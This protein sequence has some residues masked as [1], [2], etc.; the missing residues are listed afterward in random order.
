MVTGP[1][2]A[3]TV[4]LVQILEPACCVESNRSYVSTIGNAACL[5]DSRNR[6]RAYRYVLSHSDTITGMATEE[7]GTARVGVLIRMQ[8]PMHDALARRAAS[9]HVSVN[10]YLERLVGRD[11]GEDTDDFVVVPSPRF[12]AKGKNGT[13]RPTKGARKG[14]TLRVVPNLRQRINERAK[15]LHLTANDYLESLVSRDISAAPTPGEEMVFD[16]TA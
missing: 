10:G 14:M 4:F 7:L 15:S 2:V 8:L 13:G 3:H 5:D 16:Q 9:E 1:M 6:R 12:A 11:L